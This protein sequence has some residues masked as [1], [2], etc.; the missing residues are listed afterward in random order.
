MNPP[1]FGPHDAKLSRDMDLVFC[2]CIRIVSRDYLFSLIPPK[3]LQSCRET[4]N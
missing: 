4:C 2:F 1:V 3:S